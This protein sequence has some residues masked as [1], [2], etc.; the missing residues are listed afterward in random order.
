MTYET[1]REKLAAHY[2]RLAQQPG[3]LDYVRDRVRTM[4]KET[5]E[6]WADLP[7]MVAERLPGKP[8]A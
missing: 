8:T 5:P 7:R 1:Q 4:A 6:L 3:W 2:A